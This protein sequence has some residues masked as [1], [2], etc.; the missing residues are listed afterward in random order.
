MFS[1]VLIALGIQRDSRAVRNESVSVF[2]HM[3]SRYPLVGL[4]GC[5]DAAD[6]LVRHCCIHC[7]SCGAVAQGAADLFISKGFF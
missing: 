5:D 3:L 7:F 6:I 4:R 2:E 1:T